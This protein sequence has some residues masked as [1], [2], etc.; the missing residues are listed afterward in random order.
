MFPKIVGFPPKS[1]IKKIGF[2]ILFTIHLGVPLFLENL[3][4][5]VLLSCFYHATI[6]WVRQTGSPK[7][8]RDG[9]LLGAKVS[10]TE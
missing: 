7:R 2:S 5:C 10:D 9:D 6:A 3:H 8:R 1:S 4:I